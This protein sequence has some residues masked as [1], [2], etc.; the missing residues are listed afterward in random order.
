VCAV[1]WMCIRSVYKCPCQVM[2]AGWQ[3]VSTC[4]QGVMLPLRLS[5]DGSSIGCRATAVT[6]TCVPCSPPAAL[7]LLLLLLLLLVFYRLAQQRRPASRLS[8]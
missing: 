3:A 5:D 6:N 7:L 2:L 4:V 1:I 8:V